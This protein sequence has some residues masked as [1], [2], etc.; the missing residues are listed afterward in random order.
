MSEIKVFAV[1]R[2]G[3]LEEA[4]PI[5]AKSHDEAVIDYTCRWPY[6]TPEDYGVELV[7]Y[8][9]APQSMLPCTW[10][11]DEERW[12]STCGLSWWLTDGTPAE[13]NMN[14]CPKCGGRITEVTP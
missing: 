1:H 4:Y 8:A 2:D 9:P 10:R 13:N 14:F 5:M 7:E 6:G 11:N 3:K 12:E